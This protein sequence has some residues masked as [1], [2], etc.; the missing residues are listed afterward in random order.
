MVYSGMRRHEENWRNWL[1]AQICDQRVFI[2]R[3]G[4]KPKINLIRRTVG[5]AEQAGGQVAGHRPFYPLHLR[6]I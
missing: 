4:G 2:S 3:S 6:L 1:P 5:E